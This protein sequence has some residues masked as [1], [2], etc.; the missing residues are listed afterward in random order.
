MDLEEEKEKLIKLV[1]SYD[2]DSISLRY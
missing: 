1:K 2:L